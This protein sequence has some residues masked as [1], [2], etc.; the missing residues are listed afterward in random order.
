VVIET[1]LI[2][3]DANAAGVGSIDAIAIPGTAMG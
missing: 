1:I 2:R 3:I